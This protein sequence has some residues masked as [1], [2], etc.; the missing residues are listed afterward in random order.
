MTQVEVICEACRIVSLAYQSIGDF[1]YASDGFCQLCND[2]YSGNYH[3][4]GKALEYVR[5]AVIRALKQDGYF[6]DEGLT[7]NSTG[8]RD[9]F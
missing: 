8:V 7:K 4:E 2:R 9:G 1:S 3:N 6:V 5:L